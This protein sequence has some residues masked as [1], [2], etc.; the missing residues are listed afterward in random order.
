MVVVMGCISGFLA[1][2][3]T[4]HEDSEEIRVLAISLPT[5]PVTPKMIATLSAFSEAVIDT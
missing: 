2:P 4:F 3:Y 1:T 5:S